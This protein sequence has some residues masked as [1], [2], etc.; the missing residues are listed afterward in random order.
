[1]FATWVTRKSNHAF[2]QPCEI[3]RQAATA[4]TPDRQLIYEIK[5]QRHDRPPTA[6]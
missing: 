4:E 5:Q 2:D 3:A 6:T 1:M